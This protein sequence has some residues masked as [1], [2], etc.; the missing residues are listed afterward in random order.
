MEIS[1]HQGLAEKLDAMH[2]GLDAA[3]AVISAPALPD[4]SAQIARGLDCIVACD[5]TCA[6]GLPRFGIL[7]RGYERMSAT[8]GNRIMA[9][10]RVVGPVCGDAAD[11]LMGRDLV[12]QLR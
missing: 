5:G 8:G 3:T 12:Q 7:A 9:F 11:V 10:A 6:R 1:R 2:F 4:G